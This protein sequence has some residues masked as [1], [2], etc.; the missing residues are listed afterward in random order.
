MTGNDMVVAVAN[1]FFKESVGYTDRSFPVVVGRA[2]IA[3][4]V[5]SVAGVQSAGSLTM[6]EMLI[7]AADATEYNAEV[8]DRLE[9][10]LKRIMP[11]EAER[12]LAILS[13]S[14]FSTMAMDVVRGNPRNVSDQSVEKMV[15]N[16]R[17]HF[18]TEAEKKVARAVGKLKREAADE[19]ADFE[20]SIAK[21]DRAIDDAVVILATQHNFAKGRL[22]E[23][24]DTG[25]AAISRT[26]G[27]LAAGSIAIGI[28]VAIAAFAGTG[29]LDALAGQTP[30]RA[31][32]SLVVGLAAGMPLMGLPNLR[33]FALKHTHDRKTKELRTAAE[34]FGYPSVG[35]EVTMT[36]AELASV[37]DAE[38]AARIT[39]IRETSISALDD[40]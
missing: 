20:A 28:G 10:S 39:K 1:K 14:D 34:T 13:T 38:L 40:Q 31:A 27:W 37:L 30:A 23:V 21:R 26:R 36:P 25:Q 3:A 8:F 16:V 6:A 7:S 33:A 29:Y 35:I 9:G 4:L 5:D 19:R 17:Q 18:A 2:T 11:A 24:L 22:L 15:D 32:I 12:L